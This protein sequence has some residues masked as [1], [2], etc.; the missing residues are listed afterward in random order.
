MN[1]PRKNIDL[2][3][4]F[5]NEYLNLKILLPKI[6]STIK[7]IK[8]FNFRIIMIDDGSTDEGYSIVTKFKKK[9]KKLLILR[10][11]KRLGQTYCYKTYLNKF[12]SHAFIRMDADNQ[13]D[14]KYLI[15]ISK[16]ILDNYDMILS[17]RKLRKHS[18][19]MIILTFLY[20]KL[21]ALLI[22]TKLKTYSSSLA[23]FKTKYIFKKNLKFN[24]HRY[25]PIIALHNGI[26]K[27]KVFPVMH[28]NRLYGFT[29]YRIYRKIIFALPEFLYFFYR[30]KSGFFR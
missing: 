27:I 1:K 24:D 12:K 19:Y 28:K 14:P 30:L 13:D 7:K 22:G 9:Y 16:L 23:Y 29:K 6:I 15:Q 20:D 3:I 25:F 18:I 8:K 21:I 11:N 2:V 17:D 10:N 26:K 4:P 5:N